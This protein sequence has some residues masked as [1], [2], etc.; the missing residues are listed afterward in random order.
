[1]VN[2]CHFRFSTHF[3]MIA[4]HLCIKYEIVNLICLKISV[5]DGQFYETN[6]IKIQIQVAQNKTYSLKTLTS[7]TMLKMEVKRTIERKIRREKELIWKFAHA[8]VCER[9]LWCEMYR[10]RIHIKCAFP[11][12]QWKLM[13]LESRV[14][15]LEPNK[16][17]YC[18]YG[19]HEMGV[20]DC[21]Y[22]ICIVVYSMSHWNGSIPFHSND[23]HT[24]IN[25][26]LERNKNCL[27]IDCSWMKRRKM[28]T[29]LY[30][31]ITGAVTVQTSSS[32][33]ATITAST[34]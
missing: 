5:A 24:L 4:Q 28:C 3:V 29:S 23:T 17:L 34:W 13:L 11:H 25:V 26:V 15:Y 1:M 9:S 27:I 7:C 30:E 18:A 10:V 2:S 32:S 33:T 21:V 19:W 22:R 8:S 6:S 12:S 31:Q 14:G 16:F 20:Y